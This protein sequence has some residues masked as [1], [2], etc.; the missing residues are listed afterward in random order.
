MT[1]GVAS[2]D[3]IKRKKYSQI[4]RL[5]KKTFCFQDK[6]ISLYKNIVPYKEIPK[7]KL[8]TKFKRYIYTIWLNQIKLMQQLKFILIKGIQVEE[9]YV[10]NLIDYIIYNHK[11]SFSNHQKSL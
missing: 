3:R 11:D 10:F 6:F 4:L 7:L 5:I 2:L 9:G 1:S 8:Y